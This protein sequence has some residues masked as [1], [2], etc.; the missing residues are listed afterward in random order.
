MADKETKQPEQNIGTA[1]LQKAA[2][3]LEKMLTGRF[4]TVELQ[5]KYDDD[6]NEITS[7]QFAISSPP[8][9]GHNSETLLIRFH[10]ITSHPLTMF[11][12]TEA[13]GSYKVTVRK[14]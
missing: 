2:S 4:M 12:V 3:I 1:E 10:P 13:N 7:A 8:K 5:R 9:R 14:R 6:L 11:D